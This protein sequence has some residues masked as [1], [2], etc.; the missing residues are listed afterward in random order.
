MQDLRCGT[1]GNILGCILFFFL[2]FWVV[3][4]PRLPWGAYMHTTISVFPSVISVGG[5][6]WGRWRSRSEK[7]SNSGSEREACCFGFTCCVFGRIPPHTPVVN[8]PTLSSHGQ[9]LANET[10]CILRCILAHAVVLLG[11]RRAHCPFLCLE[12]SMCLAPC[13]NSWSHLACSDHYTPSKVRQDCQNPTSSLC[14]T[15]R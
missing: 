12:R 1:V 3:L 2:L 5:K 15:S 13:A 8:C 9:H 14:K 6:N 11:L 7:S 10:N 4:T